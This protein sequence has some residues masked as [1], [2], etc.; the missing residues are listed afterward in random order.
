MHR[1]EYRIAYD[2][3]HAL[4]PAMRTSPHLWL[5]MAECCLGDHTREQDAFKDL[6]NGTGGKGALPS[7]KQV[8]ERENRKLV[9]QQQKES[10]APKNNKN[11]LGPADPLT[12]T[13]ALSCLR[14][15]NYLATRRQ[16]AG[17]AA[18]PTEFQVTAYKSIL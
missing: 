7:I 6:L 16:L 8:G 13:N 4:E 12:L 2:T 14:K 5:H 1:G 18:P 11:D 9:L 3:L 15:A 17:G 10:A